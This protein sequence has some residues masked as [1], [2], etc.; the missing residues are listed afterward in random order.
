MTITLCDFEVNI[1]NFNLKHKANNN[2][3]H[4]NEDGIYKHKNRT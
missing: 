2:I 4:K 3:P 1:V